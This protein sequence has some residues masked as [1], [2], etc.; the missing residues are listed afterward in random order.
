MAQQPSVDLVSTTKTRATAA[1]TSGTTKSHFNHEEDGN[2]TLDNEDRIYYDTDTDIPTEPTNETN[3]C[4]NQSESSHRQYSCA[5]CRDNLD[6]SFDDLLRENMHRE[7]WTEEQ[8]EAE[9]P[10]RRFATKSMEE[11]VPGSSLSDQAQRRAWSMSCV[12]QLQARIERVRA[13]HQP[14]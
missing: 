9:E 10:L 6:A 4:E 7:G 2:T 1:S 12:A 3:P 14:R 5:T 13:I 11:L 8:I